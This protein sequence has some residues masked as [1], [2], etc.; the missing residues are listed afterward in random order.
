MACIALQVLENCIVA[1]WADLLMCVCG[2]QEAHGL[3]QEGVLSE[4]GLTDRP[5]H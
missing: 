1:V 2:V 5:W 3:Q 4:E